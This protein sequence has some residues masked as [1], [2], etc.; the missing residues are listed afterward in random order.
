MDAQ[1][2][3]NFQSSSWFLK[4]LQSNWPIQKQVRCDLPKD[5]GSS[6]I[7]S[8]SHLTNPFFFEE[9]RNFE[10]PREVTH[11]VG[12]GNLYASVIGKDSKYSYEIQHWNELSLFEKS[13]K[14]NLIQYLKRKQIE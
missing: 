7:E 9:Q 5:L 3:F 11:F 4:I 6:R 14:N 13:Y 1:W 8:K 2:Y 10:V 12:G